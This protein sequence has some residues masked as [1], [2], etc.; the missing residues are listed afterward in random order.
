MLEHVLVFLWLESENAYNYYFTCFVFQWFI[1]QFIKYI[2][3]ILKWHIHYLLSCYFSSH[4]FNLRTWL[5]ILLWMNQV[6]GLARFCQC[7]C[8]KSPSVLVLIF[9]C[10]ID[11]SKDCKFT[12]LAKIGGNTF[13]LYIIFILGYK[14]LG[15]ICSVSLVKICW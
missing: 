15:N 8:L 10:E 4:L 5:C 12:L 13:K 11:S 7:Y 1:V 3:F 9:K 14:K 6:Q 2:K